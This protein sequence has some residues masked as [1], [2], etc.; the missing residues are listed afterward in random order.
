L[1][2]SYVLCYLGPNIAGNF[3]DIKVNIK[4]M[5]QQQTFD[6]IL[7]HAITWGNTILE[8]TSSLVCAT[9]WEL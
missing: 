5:S 2:K 9:E 6:S 7:P 8:H 1:L 4:D 3:L